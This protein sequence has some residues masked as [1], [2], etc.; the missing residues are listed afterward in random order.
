MG[1]SLSVNLGWGIDLR[2]QRESSREAGSLLPSVGITYRF[3]SGSGAAGRGATDNGDVRPWTGSDIDVHAVWAPLYDGVWAAGAG[4]NI[5]FGVVDRSPPRIDVSY[6]EIL[7]ISPNN[8][9][10]SDDLLLPVEITDERYINRWALEITDSTGSVIRRI[11]NK[12]ERPENEGFRNIVD[13][14]LYVKKGVAIPEVIRWD[15]RTDGGGVAPDGEYTFTVSAADDNDNGRSSASYT[16]VVDNTPPAAEFAEPA[17]PD[18]LIFSPNNDGIKDELQLPVE[19]S[20]E[21][22]WLIEVLDGGEGVVRTET[23]NDDALETF[24]WNGTDNEG[25]LVPDGVYSVRLSATD[26]AGNSGTSRINNIIVDTEPTPIALAVDIAHFSPNGDGRRD[27][28]VFT[29]DVPVLEGIR[30]YEIVVRDQAGTA[31]RTV[32]GTDLPETWRFDGRGDDGRILPEGPYRGEL[33]LRYRHGNRPTATSP[34][35]ILDVTPPRLSVRADTPVFSPNG[36]GRIDVVNF[37]QTTDT[38]PSWNASIQR[39]TGAD[40]AAVVRRYSWTGEPSEQLQWDGRDEGGRRVPDGQYRY[41]LT[42]EDRAANR[43]ASPGVDIELDTR[44]TP[45]YIY[46]SSTG[47]AVRAA[48]TVEAFSPN[49]DGV[50]DVINLISEIGDPRGAERFRIEILNNDDEIVARVDGSGAPQRSYPW[51]GRDVT[52]S[53][54]PDGVYRAR[55][56]VTYRHGNRPETT[57]PTFVLDT[58]NPT[59]T[60]TVADAERAFSPDGDGDKD[61]I[62]IRQSSSE[63]PTWNARIVR[64]GT[65]QPVRTWRFSGSLGELVWDGIGDDEEVVADGT[66]YYEVVGTDDAGNTTRAR[67]LPFQT[68][69]RDIELRLRTTRTDFSPNNDGVMD[70]VTFIPEANID[71][72]VSGWTLEIYP[73]NQAGTAGS[74]PVFTRT[75]TGELES[76]V[77]NGRS[78]AGAVVPDGEYRGVITARPVQR[79]EPISAQGAR[80]VTVDTVAPSVTVDLSTPI[81]SPNGDGRLDELLITQESSEEPLWTATITDES[82]ETAG[83]WEWVGT[84]PRQLRFAGLTTRQRRVSDGMYT[85]VVT[86]TDEAGNTGRSTPRQFEVYT[87]ETPLQFYAQHLAFSPNGDGVKD[88]VPFNADVALPEDVTSW[89]LEISDGGDNVVYRRSGDRRNVPSSLTWTGSGDGGRRAPEGTYTGALTVEYRHGNIAKGET[90][91]FT[92][93]ITP[94][95]LDVRVSPAIF[96]PDGDDSRDTLTVTQSGDPAEGWSGAITAAD[97]TVIRSY[98]WNRRVD[99]FVWDG[100]DQA[101]NTVADGTYRYRV[102]GTDEAGNTTRYQSEAITIDTR[103]T[104]IFVTVSPRRFSPNGDGVADSLAIGLITNRL[105]G[106]ERGRV[107]IIDQAERVIRTLE[108]TPTEPRHSVL[109]DGKN[110]AGRIV[111]GEY[112]VR[113]IVEYNNGARP[114]VTSPAVTVDTAGPRLN[115]QLR[116]LPFSPDNDGLNDELAISLSANDASPIASWSIDILDRGNRPFYRF[117]GSGTPRRELIWDG[118]SETGET[119]ISAEDYPY[120]FTVVDAVGNRS[121]VRGVIPIDILVVRE[122]DLLKVQISNINFEPNTPALQLDPSTEAGAKNIAVLDR[123]VEVFDKYASYRIRVEGHA[124]NITGTEREEREELQPLSLAR[125][126]TVREAL[127]ERGMDAERISTVGRGGTMPIVPHSDEENRWKNRRVEFILLR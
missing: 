57:S 87:A 30:E 77:W 43:V 69:T 120:R 80:P 38:A 94:P 115:V 40:E 52:G 108:A 68:D 11:E 100:S 7:Y 85:Y 110:D 19:T 39:V 27:I 97:G 61:T 14:L 32:T 44:E 88:N 121:E 122:G 16:V 54:A 4:T 93:D 55:L 75:G 79:A 3:T 95:A 109:W 113:Y 96:S 41:V 83:R 114:R 103:P 26:R 21:D 33:Q 111:D 8:D 42:G 98:S 105:E 6:P 125:A 74:S 20:V 31:R 36:D 123:L 37:I 35:I 72:T 12:E 81:I 63:E 1:E 117:E 86:A 70:D 112:T 17:G 66:Y 23:V 102:E 28:V 60:A 116:G 104:R 34:E 9:G 46:P 92:L 106:A 53:V 49:G 64:Q 51:D 124:V 118:R 29:P 89:T 127:I 71:L 126:R 84:A 62:L 2:E 47:T 65:N 15:G 107:E 50:Q 91:P 67:T 101:G 10:R 45:V 56:I 99:S 5:A 90:D 58:Q 25:T 13:R 78:N 73:L 119:V 24:S 76:V 48:Q 59:V 18:E 22:R 82:G